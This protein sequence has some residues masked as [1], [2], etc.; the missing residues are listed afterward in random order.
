MSAED[1]RLEKQADDILRQHPNLNAQEL[2]NVPEVKS[3]LRDFLTQ[4][5]KDAELQK[6]VS[7]SVAFTAEMRELHEP[8]E[9]L[10]FSIDLTKYSEDRTRRMLVS[11][12][13]HDANRVVDFFE[14]ETSEAAA[15]FALDP[16]AA[17]S[18]NGISVDRKPPPGANPQ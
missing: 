3:G 6:R 11:L 18:N 9:N 14:K 16:A 10:R 4:L 5:S 1:A 2:L 15:E 13:S 8:K 12:L 7:A 17:K